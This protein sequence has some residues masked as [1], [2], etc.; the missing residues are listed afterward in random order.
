MIGVLKTWT[1]NTTKV[2]TVP[3]LSRLFSFKTFSIFHSS[4][5]L[6]TYYILQQLS[7]QQRDVVSEFSVT[8]QLATGDA[9]GH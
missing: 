8:E 4:Q 5:K 3:P 1:E 6:T 2:H 7:K 9:I